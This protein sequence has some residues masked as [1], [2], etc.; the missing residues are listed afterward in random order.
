M[1]I[2]V[3]FGST[4]NGSGFVT[5]SRKLSVS[6]L[7]AAAVTSGEHLVSLNM[8]GGQQ[9]GNILPVTPSGHTT[10]LYG[11]TSSISILCHGQKNGNLQ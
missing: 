10:L 11:W 6:Y 3:M 7:F 2:G 8:H 4:P 9:N 5:S 1:T